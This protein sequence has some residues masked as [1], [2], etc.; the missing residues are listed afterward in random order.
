MGGEG[1]VEK[2]PWT[3]AASIA[4]K[5]AEQEKAKGSSH[6][7]IAK[8]HNLGQVVPNWAATRGTAF[9]LRVLAGQKPIL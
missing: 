9:A 8:D 7:A 2:E 5:R 3:A 4:K 6:I 1:P